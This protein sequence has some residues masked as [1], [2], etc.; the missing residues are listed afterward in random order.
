MNWTHNTKYTIVRLTSD[1]RWIVQTQLGEKIMFKVA[2]KLIAITF[3]VSALAGSAFAQS[4]ADVWQHHIKAWEARSLDEIVSDY[5]ESSVLILNNKVFRGTA[6]IKTVFADLF[7][8]FD[9]GQNNI[10][11]PTLQGRIVY[12]T[13][14]FMPPNEQE[15]FGTDT[16]VIEDGKIAIQTIASPLYNSRPFGVRN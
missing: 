4:T 2:K 1:S 14:H 8:L 7:N 16:F 10:D 5:D 13:W 9:H 11:A 6:A 3:S 15:F 12:I